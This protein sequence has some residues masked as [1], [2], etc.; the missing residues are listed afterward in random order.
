MA[1]VYPT[2]YPADAV[3]ILDTM[4][5]DPAQLKI[6]GSMSLRSQQY[7]GDYDGFERVSVSYS[8]DK[9][10]VDYLVNRF[11]QIIHN[12]TK[13][14]DTY[15]M[16]IKSGSVEEWRV[17]PSTFQEWNPEE[18][19][20]KI[21]ELLGKNIINVKM[22]EEALKLC[23]SGE[24]AYLIAKQN[25]KFHIVRW[26]PFDVA[27]GYKVL[28]DNRRFTLQEAFVS[29]V[30]TKVDVI[31]LVLG[32]RYTDFSVIYQFYNN[33]KP[34]NKVEIDPLKSITDDIKVLQ[35]EGN[36]FK[37]L[38]RMFSLARLRDN[39]KVM[40]RLTTLLNSDLGRIYSVVSDLGTVIDLH[41]KYPE[42]SLN[43]TLNNNLRNEIDHLKTKLAN[44]GLR[45][46][47]KDENSIISSLNN[48]SMASNPINRYVILEHV[49]DKLQKILNEETPKRV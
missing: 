17:V 14:P 4:A 12:L 27:R 30:I 42:A 31:G 41:A 10:A 13:L 46:Y 33:D 19:K 34:L 29:P 26:R 20:E 36:H 38:K 21:N 6:V 39:K 40:E 35:K 7:A 45:R 37:A 16:D 25:I 28:R 24:E 9:E 15:I 22:A 32:N 44:V 48:A 3:R 5:F 2:N 23:K 18:A 47:L 49:R 43:V 8:T 1:K 11:Q